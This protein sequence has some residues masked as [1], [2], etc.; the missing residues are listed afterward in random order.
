MPG[1]PVT[2]VEQCALKLSSGI[3]SSF[4]FFLC[5]G[6]RVQEFQLDTTGKAGLCFITSEATAEKAQ[7]LGAGFIWWL[8]LAVSWGL[9]GA[10][11]WG[12]GFLPAWRPRGGAHPSGQ[13]GVASSFLT[14]PHL[15]CR[16]QHHSHH[17]LGYQQDTHLARFVEGTPGMSHP[18]M[19]AGRRSRWRQACGVSA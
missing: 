17:S 15:F 18:W 6:T 8:L 19:E 12:W 3:K 10:S 16:P 7:Q 9:R 2:N 5:S 11:P 14:E 1:A 13:G 4:F